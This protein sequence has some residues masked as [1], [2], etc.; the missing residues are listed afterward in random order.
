MLNDAGFQGHSLNE[1]L[2]KG[3]IEYEQLVD[4]RLNMYYI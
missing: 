2:S 4:S 1:I 3:L